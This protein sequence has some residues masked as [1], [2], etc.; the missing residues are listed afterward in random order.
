MVVEQTRLDD[1]F[2]S[3]RMV[4]HMQTLVMA[5]WWE[6]SNDTIDIRADKYKIIRCVQAA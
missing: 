6:D 3:V 1:I 4:T 5:Y 2:V